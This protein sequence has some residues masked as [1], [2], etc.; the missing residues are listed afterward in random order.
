MAIWKGF[1]PD[2]AIA[3][4]R[5]KRERGQGDPTLP[6]LVKV[7]LDEVSAEAERIV[8]GS[9]KLEFSVAARESGVMHGWA[10]EAVLSVSVRL[11]RD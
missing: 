2:D 4:A 9:D 8:A 11:R 10:V 7:C 5:R 3:E 6:A 1:A